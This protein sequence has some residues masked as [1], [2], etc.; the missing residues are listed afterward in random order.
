MNKFILTAPMGAALLLALAP[1]TAH[2]CAC[3][4]GVFDV[5]IGTMLPNHPG[6]VAYVE[7]DTMNQNRNRSGTSS[8]PA[9]NNPDKGIRTNFFTVG[10]QYM[11]N[12][13]NGVMLDV[14]YWQRRFITTDADTGN[15]VSFRHASIGDIRLRGIYTGFSPDMSTG[16]TYGLKLPTGDSSYAGFDPDTSIGSGSTDVLL[17][18]FKTSRF[19]ERS[20]FNYFLNGELQQP[21][22]SRGDYH[23]GT[24]VDGVAGVYYSGLRVGKT[25]VVPLLQLIGS[26]RRGDSGSR[27]APKDSGYHRVLLAPGLETHFGG[28]RVFA[29]VGVPIYQNVR[30]NQLTANTLFKLTI[31]RDFG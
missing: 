31:S 25:K 19:S 23:P 28:T 13:K 2:S 11:F 22:A 17:G 3:G 7:Y 9:A 12:R 26:Y 16:V 24:E 6:G 21:V 8:A 1:R 20:R 29:Q 4:C 30:G 14:P 27:S 18:A 15:L 10:A 5:S